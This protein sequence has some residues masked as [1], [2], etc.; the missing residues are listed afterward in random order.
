MVVLRQNEL[1]R[2]A[3][4][5]QQLPK[6]T[7]TGMCVTDAGSSDICTGIWCTEGPRCV[8]RV[9][10]FELVRDERVGGVLTT[11]RLGVPIGSKY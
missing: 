6:E 11:G 4:L 3:A 10:G 9:P 5:V 2:L 1:L 7:T 8:L